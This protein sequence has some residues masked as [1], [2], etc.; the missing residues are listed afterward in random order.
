MVVRLVVAAADG[1]IGVG[2]PVPRDDPRVEP[3]LAVVSRVQW[4]ALRVDALCRLLLTA[5]DDW[6]VRD[7]FF[8]LE[9]S[10]LLDEGV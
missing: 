5:L 9:L 6:R 3:L 1:G 2:R 7:A 4:R 10:W 8:D